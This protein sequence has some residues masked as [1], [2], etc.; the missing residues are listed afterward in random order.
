MIKKTPLDP[1]YENINLAVFQ[2]NS[3]TNHTITGYNVAFAHLFRPANQELSPFVE[4]FIKDIMRK[5]ENIWNGNCYKCESLNHNKKDNTFI[6]TQINNSIEQSFLWMKHDFLNTL[7]PIMGFSDVLVELRDFDEESTTLIKKIY[8]NSK[9]MHQQIDQLAFLQNLNIKNQELQAEEYDVHAFMSE[10]SDKLHANKRTEGSISIRNNYQG[11]AYSAISNHELRLTLEKQI[12][13]FL[14]LQTKKELD[15]ELSIQ[16]DLIC[17]DISFGECSISK[18]T[19]NELLLIEEYMHDCKKIDKIQSE[20]MNYLIL[21]QIISIL[22]GRMHLKR[23]N[24]HPYGLKIFLPLCNH[25]ALEEE[26]H[27]WEN[28]LDNSPE[29]K[30]PNPLLSLPDDLFHQIQIIC[31]NFD[32][33][34]ILDQW[35]ELA[36]KLSKINREKK[37]PAIINIIKS[38]ELA[39]KTFD[40][41]KLKNMFQHCKETFQQPPS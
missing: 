12:T 34:L 19:M 37:N 17:I 38:I 22:N 33:A 32:G 3:K 18:S 24:E 40:V 41:V 9:K 1:I 25:I 29:Q 31:K 15:I 30:A 16:D 20:S 11:K 39:I 4:S 35:E 27:F 36:Q 23:D 7:N 6:I 5:G 13:F 2:V 8:E 21:Q 28:K 26:T 14:S 10:L